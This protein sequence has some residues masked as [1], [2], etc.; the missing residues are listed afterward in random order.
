MNDSNDYYVLMGVD[1]DADVDTIRSAYRTRK[2]V[3]TGED[4]KKLNKA[5]NVLS[6]P[7]Q[8][9]RYDEQREANSN[10]ADVDLTAGGEEPST[11]PVSPARSQAKDNPPARRGREPLPPTLT[12][13]AGMTLASRKSRLTA[14]VIDLLVLLIIFAALTQVAAQAVAKAQKP[15][16]VDQITALNNK[17]DQLSKDKDAANAAAKKAEANSAQQNADKQKAQDLQKQIDSVTKQRDNEEKKLEPIVIA[18]L[19]L[20]FLIGFL[21]LAIPSM[22]SGQTLGK[23]FQH[24]RVVREDGSPARVGDIIR[25]YGSIILVAFAFTLIPILG[26]LGIAL[27]LIG[28]TRWMANR[29]MQGMHDRFA[30]TIVIDDGS[31]TRS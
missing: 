15:K 19:G 1:P 28:V 22:A 8:R 21:Y 13:P 6:D 17:I 5:W 16:V 9:G 29:N 23:R 4:A 7:Y 26:V 10:G 18:F 11:S 27:V 30:H 2:E 25:R 3:A 14:M 20:A 24:V 12:L 31:S